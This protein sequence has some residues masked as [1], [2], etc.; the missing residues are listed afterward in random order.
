MNPERLRILPTLR[1]RKDTLDGR[2]VIWGS[3]IQAPMACFML[4]QAWRTFP[5]AGA[6]A[7]LTAG[8]FH[9]AIPVA[10][11]GA[12]IENGARLNFRKSPA[13]TILLS[14]I[15]GAP[16]FLSLPLI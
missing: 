4:W 3:L 6:D 7:M 13:Q 5:Q 11:I 14:L 2:I 1:A 16:F 12:L 9:L 15:A 10:L 8:L